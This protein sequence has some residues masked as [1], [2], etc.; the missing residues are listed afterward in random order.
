MAACKAAFSESA[1]THIHTSLTCLCVF[2]QGI[3]NRSYIEIVLLQRDIYYSHLSC[4]DIKEDLLWLYTN[5]FQSAPICSCMYRITFR[6]SNLLQF[7]NQ[8]LTV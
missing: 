7:C 8:T 6:E 2:E 4:T 5:I 3:I 1:N